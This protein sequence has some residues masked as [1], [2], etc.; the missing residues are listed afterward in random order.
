MT[1]FHAEMTEEVKICV[2]LKDPLFFMN[3]W[4]FCYACGMVEK[5]RARLDNDIKDNQRTPSHLKWEG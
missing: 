2:K 3:I 4:P 5:N 1:I